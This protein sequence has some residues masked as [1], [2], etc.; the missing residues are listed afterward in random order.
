M[1]AEDDQPRHIAGGRSRP[2]RDDSARRSRPLAIGP[3]TAKD[4]PIGV[5]LLW[6]QSWV[7][8]AMEEHSTGGH[9]PPFRTTLWLWPRPAVAEYNGRAAVINT[10]HARESGDSALRP[11][12]EP[13]NVV[14]AQREDEFAC[15][16]FRRLRQWRGRLSFVWNLWDT[17]PEKHNEATGRRVVPPKIKLLISLKCGAPPLGT[18]FQGLTGLRHFLSYSGKH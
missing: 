1:R 14:H 4:A 11:C 7:L 8:I 15:K 2:P 16:T 3:L 10:D 17:L 5:P 6:R 18:I 13:E 9:V 12:S